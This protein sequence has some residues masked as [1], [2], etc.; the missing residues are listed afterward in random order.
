MILSDI[1]PLVAE[2]INLPVLIIENLRLFPKWPIRSQEMCDEDTES[3]QLVVQ[4]TFPV[5]VLRFVSF[6]PWSFLAFWLSISHMRW[7]SLLAVISLS[8]LLVFIP[9][10]LALCCPPS[11][12]QWLVRQYRVYPL[13]AW[14]DL[15]HCLWLHSRSCSFIL[16]WNGIGVERGQKTLW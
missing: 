10:S 13:W 14:G 7:I 1:C 3:Q 16:L 8:L 4:V 6:L 11:C 12:D 5:V 15:A 9:P 2:L